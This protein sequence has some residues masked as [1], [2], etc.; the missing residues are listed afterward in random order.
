MINKDLCHL[1]IHFQIGSLIMKK[2]FIAASILFYSSIVSASKSIIWTAVFDNITPRSEDVTL[3]YCMEHTPTVMVTTV[4]QVLSKEGIKAL[5]GLRVNY[6]SYKSTKRDGLLFNI[7][8][9][10]ISGKDSNGE[11]STPIKMYQQT[12]SEQDQGKTWVVWSTPKCKGTFIGTP[13]II[14]D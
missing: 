3:Q 13:T 2:M 6:N 12:L 4:D 7:V 8:N 1:R 11:W 5:N 10:T 14:N 9:A